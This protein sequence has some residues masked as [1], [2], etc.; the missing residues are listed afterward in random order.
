MTSF[1]TAEDK[2]PISQTKVSVPAQH[3]L[4]YSPGQKCEFHLPA[5]INFFQPGESYLN[6]GVKLEK[7]PTNLPTKLQLD[8]EIGAHVLIKDIRIYSGGAGRILLEEYQ[9]Y[10]TITAL[11]YDYETNDTMKAKRAL[12]EGAT[13]FS[14]R[15]RNDHG[16]EHSMQNNNEE[17][18]YFKANDSSASYSTAFT[19]DQYTEVKALLQLNTGIFSNNKIF[20]IGQT[21]G[22]VVE[23][24]FEDARR[25]FR[26]LDQTARY[27]HLSTNPFFMS[28]NG[29]EDTAAPTLP[30]SVRQFPVA[31]NN[32]ST[33]TSFWLRRDNAMGWSANVDSF[34]FAIGEE[35][36]FVNAST[37]VENPSTIRDA[38]LPTIKRIEYSPG[39][40]NALLVTLN[41]SYRATTTM[42][43]E[44]VVCSRSIEKATTSYNP[45]YLI[46]NAEF[47][48]QQVEMPAGYTSKLAGLMKSGGAMNYDFLS[49]TNYKIS[50][51]AS[52][53][54]A[55]LRL[56]LSQSRAKSV[57]CIPTDASSSGT[58][59]LLEAKDTYITHYD[60][61]S[62]AGDY[63]WNANHSS[64][65]G[66]VGCI[67]NMTAYQLFY[68]G[69]L[70]PNRKVFTNKL[71]T[72]RSIDSQP[73][74]E[75]EKGL[76][77]GGIA[78]FSF[79]KFRENFA[80]GRALSLQNGVYDTRGTDF[81]L[82]VEYQ[83]T[84][85][86]AVD[87]LWHC[88]CMH[89]RRIVISGNGIALQV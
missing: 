21:E 58:K 62:A 85:A 14:E 86:P 76:Q 36:T 12:T 4:Q 47:I 66:L 27:R 13:V 89:L 22:L 44:L 29:T 78:P 82:Q 83:E 73:L 46:T 67:D 24:I 84:T 25:C 71:A 23:I 7:D 70:N 48:L 37:G 31:D 50:Q 38:T 72:K 80:I 64:R 34:P 61:E 49:G 68:D 2:I 26:T 32:G 55:N 17:N 1:W 41:A 33:F 30:N 6:L 40:F 65:T 35:I 59:E 28:S 5:G 57:L 42:S 20:P 9:N 87:K 56:P 63:E 75:L 51:L 19:N 15:A 3:G 16:I 45:S 81:A 52:E 11:K 39:V 10:N 60:L 88:W 74:I 54:V 18:P 79:K 43:Q 77:M 8:A 69:K 53:R